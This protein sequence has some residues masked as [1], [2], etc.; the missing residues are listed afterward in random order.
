MNKPDLYAVIMAGGGGTRFWPWSRQMRPKQVLPILSARTMIRETVDRVQPLVPRERILIVTSRSQ[1]RQLHREV[2]RIP[3]ENLLLEPEGK[4]TA[5]C[6]GLAAVHVQRKNP[7]AVLIVLPA[8][9]YIGA[10]EKFLRTL[11]RAAEFASRQNYLITLGI[12]PTGPETGYG[13]IQKGPVLGRVKE[14]EVFR[15][16]A[17]R[18]KP[19]LQKAQDYLRRG[20]FLWNSGMFIW[21]VGVFLKALEKYLPR[22]YGDMQEL[23]SSIGKRGERRVLEKVYS[24][25]PSISVDYGVLEKAPNVALIEARFGWNDVG[26]WAVL[27][28]LWPKDPAGNVCIQGGER[29]ESKVLVLDSSGCLV[30][31]EKSFIAVLGLKDTLV[32]EAGDAIL[33]C[34]RS[35]SQDVRRVLQELKERGWQK[36]L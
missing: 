30:R 3:P 15:A 21:R 27:W 22:L 26:S 9:H 10:P 16:K 2:D 34:P 32:V 13:Y 6:L 1:A 36:Y 19:A 33:V 23:K 7:E 8:D 14:T 20:D 18:E 25:C 28:N 4:N 12:T 29:G 11:R 17:F 35:R 5:P 24:Q 31:G